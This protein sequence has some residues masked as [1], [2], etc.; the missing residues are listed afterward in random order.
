MYNLIMNILGT[1]SDKLHKRIVEKKQ[2][3]ESVGKLS[4]Q[5]VKRIEERMQV[6][7]VY[8]TNKIEGS[9]L[10][11]GETELVLRGITVNNRSIADVLV[12]KHHPDA[13]NYIKELSL[14]PYREINE[15]DI[16]DIHMMIM[17]G[18]VKDA[19]KYRQIDVA[20]QGA[21]FTPPPPYEISKHMKELVQFINKNPYE[22]RPIELAAHVHYYLSWIHPFSDGNGRIA[23]LLMNF[24]II[25][26][27][28]R[29]TV[30]KKVDGKKYLES[31]KLADNGNFE[32]FLT[33]IA[34]CVEQTLD[35][36]LVEIGNKGEKENL[37]PLSELAEKTPY[38]D[39]Y[40][41]LLARKGQIDAIKVGRIWKS[42]RKTIDTYL[43]EHKRRTRRKVNWSEYN[44]S[45]VKR[46]ELLF[47]AQFFIEQ[48]STEDKF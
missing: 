38:S 41:G 21:S 47:D 10:T 39:E 9:A 22:L 8:N 37:L 27:G 33:F 11:R 46:G 34:R 20:V 4:R 40:L 18:V 3:L 24:I 48:T 2:K 23:R 15:R 36:Y 17:T 45:L 12:A 13:L 19:G 28:Y 25:S 30:I 31:L 32:H 42:T 7:F 35:L 5:V 29:F 16:K 43:A 44:E 1:I 26:N 6:E 14:N